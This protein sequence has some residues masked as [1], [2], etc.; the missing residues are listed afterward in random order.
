[1]RVA[2]LQRHAG[3]SH[4]RCSQLG[5]TSHVMKRGFVLRVTQD[6]LDLSLGQLF[7]RKLSANDLGPSAERSFPGSYPKGSSGWRELFDASPVAWQ[8]LGP[9]QADLPT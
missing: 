8:L 2:V 1:M 9:R 3:R 6:A 4:G 7:G 5:A